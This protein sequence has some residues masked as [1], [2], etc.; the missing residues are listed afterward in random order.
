M[1]IERRRAA[2]PMEF[3]ARVGTA[4]AIVCALLI[5]INWNA[6]ASQRFP[7]PDDI[8]RLVQV[9]DLIAGQGWFDLTQYRVDAADGGV[10]MHWSRI[11][12]L[13]LA[14]VIV[15]LTPV[16]GQAGAETAALVIV[17]LLT[18]G[19]AMLL[20]ARIA[21][22]LMGDEEATLT[23]LVLAISVPVL[24]QLGPMRIDHHGWQIVCALAAINGLMTRSP[25]IGGMV[26]GASL[27]AWLSISIEGLPLAAV[28]FA[29]LALRWLRVREERA[30]LVTAIQSLALVSAALYLLTRGFSDIQTY[31]DA[32]SPL[33]LVMFGWGAIALT[34]LARFEPMPRG[35]VL[36]GF[37]LTGGGA[38]AMLAFAAPQCA[39]GGGFAE[40]DPLVAGYWHANVLEGQPIWRQSLLTALQ[41]AVTP[42]IGLFAA[43]NLASRS[44]DWLRRFWADYAM[45]LAGA[46]LVAIFVSRAGAVACVLAAPPLAWQLRE[47]LRAIRKIDRPAP[48]LA[49]LVG[50]VFALLPA[51][52]AM[53]LTSAM[54]AR[55]SLGGAADA[56]VKAIDCRVQDAAATLAS[57]PH[58]EFYAPL[59]IAP[60]LLLVSDHTVLA[61]GHHRG[62]EAM[63]LLIETA[64]APQ[65]E[66]EAR[67]R[68]R[69][70]QYVALC[71][72]LGEA[73]MYARLQPEGFVADLA[74]GDVPDWLEPVELEQAGLKLWKV[75]PDASPQRA[76]PDGNPSPRR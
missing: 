73:R 11:V 24:F 67:L 33:H 6:I 14:A 76:K 39:T 72:T 63:K 32:I 44:R 71:P 2:F 70:T 7:D 65:A 41:Y 8:L 36:G 57:L 26:I 9:R 18:L 34:V 1:L 35:I 30:L 15:V 62:Y 69:G 55:A 51:L 21:W 13:P 3:L 31:C 61:T 47:W 28:I 48:R 74:K 17:P 29:V 38:I 46:L 12:D 25:K 19:I 49:A 75:V 68:E 42:L 50:V 52:P 23:S 58:G 45:I 64:L 20:A 10:A 27:A 59:D 60:E 5:A 4:W 53:L 54:P 43:A 56:P 66:A 16:L 22:R 40:L 37:A